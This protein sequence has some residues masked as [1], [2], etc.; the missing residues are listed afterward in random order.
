MLRQIKFVVLM[1]T[2]LMSQVS[3]AVPEA[4][5]K[6][7]MV[8]KGT[9]TEILAQDGD[10]FFKLIRTGEIVRCPKGSAWSTLTVQDNFLTSALSGRFGNNGRTPATAIEVATDP[11]IFKQYVL[12]LLVDGLVVVENS[13]DLLNTTRFLD[14]W[15]IP[16]VHK[17]T[18]LSPFVLALTQQ[19]LTQEL[20][21]IE[22]AF[23]GF[24]PFT[25]ANGK[26][27][28][29]K[30]RLKWGFKSYERGTMRVNAWRECSNSGSRFPTFE[31]VQEV[32]ENAFRAR[33]SL[34]RAEK[35]WFQR[36]LDLNS[37]HLVER[38][39]TN[40]FIVTNEDVVEA[41]LQ[42]VDGI[43][44][45]SYKKSRPYFYY[46]CNWVCVKKLDFLDE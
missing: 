19:A 35:Q 13:S 3:S 25:V 40:R 1:C 44:H 10:V 5:D 32:F 26:L 36:M 14:S 42:S 9:M 30:S 29:Q 43:I 37:F 45:I 6:P 15:L 38:D 46:F 12:N 33:Q 7:E 4:G 22:G 24:K 34:S 18:Y 39:A 20:E 41:Q 2:V 17:T 16:V 23:T 31:E 8:E 28:D 21:R 11:Q 27:I